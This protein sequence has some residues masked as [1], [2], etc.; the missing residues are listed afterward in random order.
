MFN[1]IKAQIYQLSR[2][3]STYIILIVSAAIL[4]LFFAAEGFGSEQLNGSC[5]AVNSAE[6]YSECL[7]M[8]A[9]LY[10]AIICAG[11]MKDKTMNYEML[12]G[13]KRIYVYCGR[14]IVSLLV[15]TLLTV[16]LFA[17]P[18]LIISA[19][20]GW[21]YAVPVSDVILRWVSALLP[22]MRLTMFYAMVSFIFKSPVLVCALGYVLTFLEMILSLFIQEMLS[23][24]IIPMY[25]LSF[26]N[27]TKLLCPENYGYGFAEEKDIM[28]VK[29]LLRTS[30]ALH[31]MAAGMLGIVIFGVLGY[32]AFRKKDMG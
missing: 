24:K 16:I 32:L 30:T 23:A 12:S 26:Y 10:T 2:S 22:M 29:D 18:T 21:G 17:V 7:P 28:V 8:F 1:V 15:N 5:F 6:L 11:D 9:M 14:I 20:Y 31:G 19:I 13:T 25:C 27:M 3:I 4:V